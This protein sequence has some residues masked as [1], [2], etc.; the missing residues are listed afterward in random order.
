M[1]R[2]GYS[3]IEIIVALALVG[4]ALAVAVPTYMAFEG[5]GSDTKAKA[6]LQSVEVELVQYASESSMRDFA[7]PNA[8]PGGGLG[9]LASMLN[10]GGVRFVSGDTPAG[11]S[12][13]TPSVSISTS[14]ASD[15]AVAAALSGSGSCWAVKVPAKDSSAWA[16]DRTPPAG[17]CTAAAWA[18]R[19][20]QIAGTSTDP[21]IIDLP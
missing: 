2:R 18:G 1:R 8:A 10:L 19:A 11:E 9:G 6:L 4:I 14:V 17:G 7:L 3:L 13:G 5:R 12:G 16:V 20:G 21:T 15:L